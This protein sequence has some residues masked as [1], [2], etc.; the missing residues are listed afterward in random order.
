MSGASTSTGQ[1]G[2]K[3]TIDS[4]VLPKQYLSQELSDP[5]LRDTKVENDKTLKDYGI[6]EYVYGVYAKNNTTGSWNSTSKKGSVYNLA[7]V[8]S[9]DQKGVITKV[10]GN[11]DASTCTNCPN[12][13]IGS[14]TINN[15]LKDAE[16]SY[17]GS[18]DDPNARFAY[19]INGF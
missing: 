19:P 10:S 3:G 14:G 2:A 1:I 13:L 11:F 17:T 5:S 8:V 18:I 7:V 16:S 4:D 6:G 9:D 15:N 12:T